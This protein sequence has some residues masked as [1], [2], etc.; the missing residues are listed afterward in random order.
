MG[1][2]KRGRYLSCEFPQRQTL[3]KYDPQRWLKRLRIAVAPKKIRYFYVGE[4]GDTTFR[5]HYHVALFGLDAIAAGGLTGKDGVVNSTWGLGN[6]FVGSLTP[7]SASYIAGYVT[8]KMTKKDDG[9]LNGREPEFARMSLRP[10]IGA[11]SMSDVKDSVESCGI[12]YFGSTGSLDVPSKLNMGK[13]S[14]PLGRYLRRKLREQLGRSADAPEEAV[15][16]YALQMRVLFE[17][18]AKTKASP[19]WSSLGKLFVDMN[20]Q[21]VLNLEAKVLLKE[22][23]KKL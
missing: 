4:Y 14:L 13:S 19:S 3:N 2:S 9:R 20:K 21:K 12:D 11:L 23:V 8:K 22:G 16:E 5:P 15:K 18:Y 6:T 17:D 1:S 7:A 10:G